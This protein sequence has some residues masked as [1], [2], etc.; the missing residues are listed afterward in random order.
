MVFSYFVGWI[1]TVVWDL[2]A[3]SFVGKLKK[4]RRRRTPQAETL[5]MT[6]ATLPIDDRVQHNGGGDQVSRR[7][8]LS[9]KFTTGSVQL[10]Q[11]GVS[12]GLDP[13]TDEDDPPDERASERSRLEGISI[14]NIVPAKTEFAVVIV[15]L[16]MV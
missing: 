10:R 11:T 5:E 7:S 2:W 16:G 6:T 13:R 12:A 15:F 14:V 8:I 9:L 3:R 4:R 1:S